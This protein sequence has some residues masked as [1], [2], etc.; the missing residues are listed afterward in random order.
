[1]NSLRCKMG[2]HCFRARGDTRTCERCG[3]SYTLPSPPRRTP[4]NNPGTGTRPPLGISFKEFKL[5][6]AAGNQT[7]PPELIA[8]VNLGRFD[9]GGVLLVSFEGK[10]DNVDQAQAVIAGLV[11]GLGPSF[12]G[13]VVVAFGVKQTISF[14]LD[15]KP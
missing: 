12:K 4:T 6:M 10:A 9:G 7:P 14:T 13:E 11:A 1:M 8:S 3:A 5:E 2:L 15:E